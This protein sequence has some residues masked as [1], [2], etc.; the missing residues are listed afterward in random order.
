MKKAMKLDMKLRH[1]D[2]YQ[3]W[4]HQKIQQDQIV[5]QWLLTTEMSTDDLMKLLL[6][7][8]QI[9]FIK[10]L[11]LVDILTQLSGNLSEE[12]S[13]LSKHSQL[14]AGAADLEDENKIVYFND[15]WQY[16]QLQ[17]AWI[18]RML[19]LRRCIKQLSCD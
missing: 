1:V 4:L 16:L 8:Q 11:N 5:I 18:Q 17:Q 14:S 15:F 19:T 13:N 7:Q 9:L 10:Q 2:I 6:V 3:H 12:L